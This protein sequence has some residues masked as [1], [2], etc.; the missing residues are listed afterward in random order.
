M[1]LFWLVF[2]VFVVAIAVWAVFTV[3]WAV[4]RNRQLKMSQ[5]GAE[6]KE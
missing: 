1:L 3:R 2:G 4:R 6:L 5:A